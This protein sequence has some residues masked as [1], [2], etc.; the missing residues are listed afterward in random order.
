MRRRHL[1]A[2]VRIEQA[3]NGH[4]W[5]YQL[6]RNELDFP[7]SRHYLVALV[8][9]QVVGFGGLMQTAD[10]GHI[11]TMAVEAEFRRRSIGVRL[12]LALL[13]TAREV[14]VADATLEVRASNEPA[15]ALYRRFGFAPEG[16]RPRYY[17]APVEDALILWARGID[18]PT[19]RRRT[20]AIR[21]TLNP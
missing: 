12:L 13:E 1:S 6:F 10:E 21:A 3:T 2:V 8:G 11:T 15:Q 7:N 5:S 4:P 16:V 17:R 14:G 20:E 19:H 18:R 9:S